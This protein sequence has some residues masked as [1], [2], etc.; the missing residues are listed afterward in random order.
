MTLRGSS[1][2]KDRRRNPVAGHGENASCSSIFLV[3][4][5]ANTACLLPHNNQ[6]KLSF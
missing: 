1:L 3:W 5:L 2:D 4:K 6:T